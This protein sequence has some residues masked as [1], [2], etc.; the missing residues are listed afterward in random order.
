MTGKETEQDLSV[1]QE[2]DISQEEISF[3]TIILG[4]PGVGK[5]CLSLKAIK[6]VFE[7]CY[8]STIGFEF[9][10]YYTKIDNI[11][12]KLQ[13]WDTCG[14]EA[15][16][17]LIKSFYRN[18]ALA[19]VVYSIDSN[20]SFKHLDE[21]IND[22]KRESNPDVKIVLIG[23]KADK[24][25]EREVQKE[26]GEK[27][28]KDNKVNFFMETSAKTGFNV[29]KLFDDAARLLYEESKKMKEKAVQNNAIPIS[30]TSE[31][32]DTE[33]EK[34]KGKCNCKKCC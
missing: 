31:F 20:E 1:T 33:S 22:I 21:W 12:I 29:N 7:D 28:S 11:N 23:N 4:D 15:Y 10:N 17:S 19:I 6:N 16:K 14:Q 34:G 27:F 5:S 30:N 2:Q 8:N 26:M 3:K 32:S 24:E 9:L 25:Q 13:I 18:S